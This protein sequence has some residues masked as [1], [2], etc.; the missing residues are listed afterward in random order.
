MRPLR[1]SINVT[2]DGCCDHRIFNPDEATHRHAEE[3]IAQADGILLG[4]PTYELME[5]WRPIARG[6]EKPEWVEPWMES[7]ARTLDAAKKYIVSSVWE[8]PDWNTEVVR[9]DVRAAVQRLKEQPGKG[10]AVG[11]VALPR[12]LAEWGLIDEYEFIVHHKIAGEGPR[13]LSGVSLDLKLVDR[14]E[15]SSQAVAMRYEPRR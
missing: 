9:G 11:G 13:L 8:G 5:V 7:F 3:G 2:V 1:Y 15:L 10:L 6:T 12:K 4:R 14:L